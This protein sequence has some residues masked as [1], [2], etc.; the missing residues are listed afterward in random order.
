MNQFPEKH[1]PPTVIPGRLMT[2][3]AYFSKEIIQSVL[4]KLPIRKIS[5]PDGFT[6]KFYQI[7]MEEIISILC[8]LF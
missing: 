8:N 1:N 7:L 2:G 4:S 5:D 6:D 3:T